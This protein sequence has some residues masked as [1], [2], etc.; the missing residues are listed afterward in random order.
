MPHVT[1]K[2]T[3][4]HDSFTVARSYRSSL[5]KVY[6]AFVDPTIKRS[7]YA[8]GPGFIVDSYSLDFRV[9][10]KET[11]A[12][13]VDNPDFKS[14]EIRNDTYYFDIVEGERIVYG[15]SMSNAGR[16]FSASLST[17]TFEREGDGGTRLTL[18]EQITFFEGSD[19][20]AMRTTGTRQL[21]EQLAAE[22]GEDSVEIAW[23]AD[24]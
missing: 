24:A 3:T 9:G 23:G 14:E 20:V 8:E 11:G 6:Q 7:W 19:G 17:I 18:H 2:P 16:P 15:Y 1:T 4:V 12:F 10:G 13:R 5:E 21:L 22:L